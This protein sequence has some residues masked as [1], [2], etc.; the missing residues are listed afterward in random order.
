MSFQ[1]RLEQVLLTRTGSLLHY[2]EKLATKVVELS[3]KADFYDVITSRLASPEV[4]CS[5]VWPHVSDTS[6]DNSIMLFSLSVVSVVNSNGELAID[7][8]PKLRSVLFRLIQFFEESNPELIDRQTW[9]VRAMTA[10]F[11]SLKVTAIRTALAPIFSLESWAPLVHKP[12]KKHGLEEMYDQIKENQKVL[13]MREKIINKHITELVDSLCTH[14]CAIQAVQQNNLVLCIA[15]IELLSI[16]LS[17]LP[18]RRFSKTVVE[19]NNVLQ[20]L[21]NKQTTP[22]FT[23]SIHLLEY[24]LRFPID[25]FTGEV[26]TSVQ[27]KQEHDEKVTKFLTHLHESHKDK[28]RDA[29]LSLNDATKSVELLSMLDQSEVETILMDIEI[30]T[31]F[32]E[33]DTEKLEAVSYYLKPPLNASHL[34]ADLSPYPT[35]QSLAETS[36][37]SPHSLPKLGPQ[38]LALPDVLIRVYWNLRVD[39]FKKIHD[40]VVRCASRF[41]K[42]SQQAK[43]SGMSRHAVKLG[44]YKTENKFIISSGANATTRRVVHLPIELTGAQP[45]HVGEWNDIGEGDVILLAQIGAKKADSTSLLASEGV[46]SLHSAIVKRI[47]NGND[48]IK[49]SSKS[50]VIS[51]VLEEEEREDVKFNL[52]IKLPH[53]LKSYAAPLRAISSIVESEDVVLDDWLPEVIMGYGDVN[54][55]SYIADDTT[56]KLRGLSEETIK[57]ALVGYEI[58]QPQEGKKRRV[59][60]QQQSVSSNNYDVEIS[61]KHAVLN[62]ASDA[63]LG[64]SPEQLQALVSSSR[65]ALTVAKGNGSTEKKSLIA[66]IAIENIARQP[67]GRTLIV[68]KNEVTLEDIS[69]LMIDRGCPLEYVFNLVTGKNQEEKVNMALHRLDSLLQEVDKLA[70]LL[71]IQGAHGNDALSASNFFKYQIEPKWKAYLSDVKLSGTVEAV[72][73]HYPFGSVEFN[74]VFGMKENLNT[75]IE[76]FCAVAS[77]FDEIERMGPLTVLQSTKARGEYLLSMQARVIGVTADTF[78]SSE[79]ILQKARISYDSIIFAEASQ[80]DIFQTIYPLLGNSQAPPRI[81]MFGDIDGLRPTV[82]DPALGLVSGLSISPFETLI[83]RGIDSITID[84]KKESDDLKVKYIAVDG[85]ESEPQ[86]GF[87]QNL[88]ECEATI[89]YVKDHFK[90]GPV[91]IL[92]PLGSQRVL[93]KMIADN[94]LDSRVTISTIE[95]FEGHHIGR[96]VV[97]MVYTNGQRYDN[98]IIHSMFQSVTEQL[99]VIC[100]P[101]YKKGKNFVF[102]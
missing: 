96:A 97:S 91:A 68:T 77:L 88:Q 20:I 100:S 2:S 24:F 16:T 25:E 95:A 73:E 33:K 90:E 26:K 44:N 98:R 65:Q 46:Q 35:E 43:L 74:N 28:L 5:L 3:L 32:M 47:T 56:I 85:S 9:A 17:Q 53:D 61:G 15:I 81:T 75:A 76:H 83:S 38:F 30:S 8:S 52:L 79:S 78:L 42:Q 45:A 57:E 87:Y 60:S 14:I 4:F 34:L 7:D 99:V 80:L 102:N 27:L 11:S 82:G 71:S 92:T 70:S 1:D 40:H 54:A 49:S 37:S 51:A 101:R 67:S 94:E 50:F 86:R 6:T 59:L 48:R 62:E 55:G 21:K 64:I 10:L 13:P 72:I 84:T 58:I 36:L 69:N 29:I 19:H 31:K 18:T 66:T 23:P 12:L 63:V 39:S 22:A 89:A 93:L 41:K